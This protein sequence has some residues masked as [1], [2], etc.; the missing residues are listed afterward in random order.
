MSRYQ[1]IGNNGTFHQ[2]R[3]F[4]HVFRIGMAADVRIRPSVEAAIL[5]GSSVIGNQIVTQRVALINGCPQ[6]IR[7]G[8]QCQT[9]R[10]PQT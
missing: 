8:L 10:I 4:T 6:N 5:N 2:I 3:H 9:Y 7:T 1:H